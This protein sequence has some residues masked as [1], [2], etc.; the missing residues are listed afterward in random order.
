M[1]WQALVMAMAERIHSQADQLRMNAERR[2]MNKARSCPNCGTFAKSEDLYCESCGF[3]FW[4]HNDG[5][6]MSPDSP[7][8]TNE[9]GG[10]QSKVPYRCDLL[11]PRATLAVS[12]VLE[13]GSRKY[14]DD[15]WRLIAVRDHINHALSH[16]FAHLAGDRSDDH[17]EHAACRLLMATELELC[18]S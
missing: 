5:F 1:D 12:R 8:C 6:G 2:T 4:R 10:K 17:L 9:A 7:T 16:L 13:E 18:E 3:G 14:G 11:P 15:N